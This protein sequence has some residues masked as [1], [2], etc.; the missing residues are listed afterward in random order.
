MHF[1][2]VK[3]AKKGINNLELFATKKDQI[4][5]NNIKIFV[6]IAYLKENHNYQNSVSPKHKPKKSSYKCSMHLLILF[7]ID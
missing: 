3:S 7:K 2:I 6:C 1:L 5:K 4:A